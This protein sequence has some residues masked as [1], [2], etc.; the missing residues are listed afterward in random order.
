MKTIHAIHYPC[1]SPDSNPYNILLLNALNEQGITSRACNSIAMLYLV[2]LRR[3]VSTV[4]FHWLN[5]AGGQISKKPAQLAWQTAI[6]FILLFAR[7]F[8]IRTVW[9]VHD[10]EA[11]NLSNHGFV[12]Y[13]S[14]AALVN[15]LIAHSPDAARIISSSYDVALS[16]VHCIPH[17]LYP[18]AFE[19]K[20]KKVAD[21]R[22][23]QAKLRLLYFGHISPYKGLDTFASALQVA[24][25]QL[26]EAS[27]DVTIIGYLNSARYPKLSTQLTKA[28][29]LRIISDFMDCDSLNRHLEEADLIVLP[30]RHTLTSGSLIYAL[31]AG[32]PVLVSRIDSLA[33]YLSPSYSFLFEANNIASLAAQLVLICNDYSAYRLQCMGISARRFAMT[34]DWSVVAKQ[35]SRLYY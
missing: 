34:L 32:K 10:L 20:A 7:A 5:R 29:D 3:R 22:A 26:G 17:G 19:V 2:I 15:S 25:K 12:F 18:R 4:H 23:G 11:H 13:R 33:Y 1:I 27:P 30:F 28:Y 35:T 16:K 6:I 14:V 31:S 24:S 9:T 21:P 8:G